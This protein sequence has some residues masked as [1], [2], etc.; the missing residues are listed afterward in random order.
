MRLGAGVL[1]L[2]LS[3]AT[4]VMLAAVLPDRSLGEHLASR[5]PVS[6]SVNLVVPGLFAVM[7]LI[8]ARVKPGR[9]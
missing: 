6:G 3:L 1:A 2:V 9:R 7:P 4:E 8:L 5:D